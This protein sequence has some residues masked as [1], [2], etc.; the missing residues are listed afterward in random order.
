MRT[1][2][3]N[4]PNSP[5][6]Q[7]FVVAHV[8]LNNEEQWDEFRD[9]DTQ[10][11]QIVRGWARGEGTDLTGR[12][13]NGDPEQVA[14]R[15]DDPIAQDERLSH[16]LNR[17]FLDPNDD[18]IIEE[19]L[20]AQ[21]PGG[22]SFRK[23]GITAVVLRAQLAHRKEHEEK[24]ADSMPVQPQVKRQ[25][26]RSRRDSRSKSIHQRILADLGLARAGSCWLVLASTSVE[27]SRRARGNNS[28]ALYA[29]LNREINTFAGQGK[30]RR[31]RWTLN[32]LQAAYDSLDEIGDQVSN[33]I[34]TAIEE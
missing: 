6:N 10:D 8:G 2:D 22:F 27:R 33:T 16:F 32:Q 14:Q 21:G 30:K 3:L 31:D 26:L 19:M 11:Q 24:P 29:L 5:N 4:D 12:S 13:G 18:W 28:D 1:V 25:T 7:G 20:D 9:L 17:S 34:R 15:F 23:L